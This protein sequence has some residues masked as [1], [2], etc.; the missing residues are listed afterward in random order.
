MK[1]LFY[2]D[3]PQEHFEGQAHRYRCAYCKQETTHINGKLE[4]HLPGCEYRVALEKAGFECNQLAEPAH[5]DMA[6]EVD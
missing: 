5:E 4:G 6:D 2:I 3:Y 1:R